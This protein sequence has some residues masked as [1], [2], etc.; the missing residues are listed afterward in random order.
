MRACYREGQDTLVATEALDAWSVGV[1]AV[2]LFTGRPALV[3]FLEG[4][5]KVC[6]WCYDNIKLGFFGVTGFLEASIL[7]VM[8]I[9]VF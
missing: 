3:Q 8:Y 6:I 5:E 4:K 2:E 9:P 1:L 7:H